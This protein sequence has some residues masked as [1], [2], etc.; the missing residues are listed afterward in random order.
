V[1]GNCLEVCFREAADSDHGRAH[2]SHRIVVKLSTNRRDAQ[3]T[4]LCLHDQ[5][6]DST[7]LSRNV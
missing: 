3:S 4:D 2:G 1:S 7:V 6:V 5:I